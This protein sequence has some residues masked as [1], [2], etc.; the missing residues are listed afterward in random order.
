MGRGHDARE[1]AEHRRRGIVCML[2]HKGLARDGKQGHDVEAPRIRVIL[3][4]GKLNFS[5]IVRR[6]FIYLKDCYLRGGTQGAILS[7]KKLFYTSE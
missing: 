7:W 5:F 1:H 6:R 3:A 2:G 4:D